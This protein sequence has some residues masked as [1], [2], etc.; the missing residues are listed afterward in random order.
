MTS[1]GSFFGGIANVCT[2]AVDLSRYEISLLKKN[3]NI[4]QRLVPMAVLF[5]LRPL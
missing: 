3:S 4:L 5:C 1:G 2:S